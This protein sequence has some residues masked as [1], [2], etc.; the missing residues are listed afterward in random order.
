MSNI[1]KTTVREINGGLKAIRN[2]PFPAIALGLGLGW[3]F[4]RRLR[5]GSPS[6]T[7]GLERMYPVEPDYGEALPEELYQSGLENPGGRDYREGGAFD[8]RGSMK[9]VLE[10]SRQKAHAI[11]QKTGHVIE[12][13]GDK[14]SHGDGHPSN[15]FEEQRRGISKLYK[16]NPMA[17]AAALFTLGTVVGLIIPE[18]RKERELMGRVRQRL[19][20]RLRGLGHDAL[21]RVEGAAKEAVKAVKREA[22]RHVPGQE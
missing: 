17:L 13:I 12:H 15:L 4:A 11:R 10:A 9:K 2:N 20:S 21:E 5:K 18:P 22:G 3:L 16:E 8:S 6:A 14:S 1:E 19:D 7:L